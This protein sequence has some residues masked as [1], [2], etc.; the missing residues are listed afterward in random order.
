MRLSIA[1][2]CKDSAAT[3]GR[4]L[5]S[6]HAL[7]D[8]I[9][10]VDSGST[11]GTLGLLESAGARIIHSPWL[12]Y[13]RTKQLALDHCRAD[14]ILALDADE[15]PLSEL[16]A[17]ICG[18]LDRPGPTTGFLVNRKVF[19]DGKPL[20]HAWQPERR[21]RLIRRGHYRWAGLDPHDHLQPL[22]PNA[23]IARLTGDLRHDSIASWPDF[24]AKQARHAETMA[25]SMLAQGR[26]PSRFKLLTSP[27]AAY[28]KQLILRRAFL[29][30]RPGLRA[31][32][33]TAHA[34]RLKHQ[35]LFRLASQA[36][37]HPP[38]D[39]ATIP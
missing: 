36:R 21:L 10:A 39:R 5:E 25:R 18:A 2:V 9:V 12:G 13:I 28:L 26:R 15:S 7:A 20:N 23:P 31:A 33:A 4:T 22:D 8:E 3:I 38:A 6:V 32:H 24:L 1:I 30:G 17:S 34:T 37:A 35:A 27:P 11:D 19:V 14:W 16:V 29:D